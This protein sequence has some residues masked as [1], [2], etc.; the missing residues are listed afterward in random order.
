MVPL[1]GFFCLKVYNGWLPR[2]YWVEVLQEF[3]V[4]NNSEKQH[5]GLHKTYGKQIIRGLL[6]IA[7]ILFFILGIL[8]YILPGLPGTVFLILAAACFFRSS[9][10]F[11]KLVIQNRWF[12]PLVKNFRETGVVNKRAKVLSVSSIWIFTTFAVFVGIPATYSL[13][14]F[15]KVLTVVLAFSGT[16]YLWRRPSK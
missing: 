7:G 1:S 15:A 12:G 14:P 13:A 3:I 2:I 5:L 4:N 9:E 6:F 10:R 8:G 16:F 11:Y